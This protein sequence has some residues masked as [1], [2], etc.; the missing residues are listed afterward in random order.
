M[1]SQGGIRGE[2]I[3]ATGNKGGGKGQ[4]STVKRIPMV[5]K[6]GEFLFNMFKS[7]YRAIVLTVL[8]FLL[9]PFQKEM[10]TYLAP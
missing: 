10:A 3:A 4:S 1:D 8:P 5:V 6:N 9:L 2:K 7:I